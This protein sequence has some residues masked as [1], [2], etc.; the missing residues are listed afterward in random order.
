MVTSMTFADTDLA[1]SSLYRAATLIVGGFI[2]SG[3]IAVGVARSRF[4]RSELAFAFLALDAALVGLFL[5]LNFESTG[6]SGDFA[7]SF[8]VVWLPPLFLT[9]A[10]LRIRPNVQVFGLLAF[11]AVIIGVAVAHGFTDPASRQVIAVQTARFFAPQPN[12]MR[13]VMLLLA[14]AFLV[15]AAYRGRRLLVRALGEAERRAALTKFLPAEIAPLVT[16]TAADDLRRGRRQLAAILFI[17]IRDSTARAENMDPMR[18]SIFLTAFRQRV[19][20]AAEQHG[21]VV[22]KF[23][24][25]GSLVVFGLPEPKPDDA[26]RA[27]ACARMLLHLIDRWNRKRQFDPAV[28]VGIG[29][30]VGEVFFG[31][32][33]DERRQEFTVLG[34]AVNVGSR[35]EQATKTFGTPLLASAEAVE[36]AGEASGWTEVRREPLRGRAGIVRVMRPA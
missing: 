15:L 11:A 3:L 35:L 25:D 6:L 36:A 17:D 33:G 34:D 21:G 26:G 29:V 1:A 16:D 32:V 4:Y 19:T 24:G 20:R 12:I 27:L 9:V 18:L 7:A 10:V 31:V 14:G 30:H 13:L 5:H 8:P 23:I 2:A 22:D 28:R